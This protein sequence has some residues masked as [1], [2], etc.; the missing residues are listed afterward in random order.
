MRQF[1]VVNTIVDI[2]FSGKTTG[3]YVESQTETTLDCKPKIYI[4]H[5]VT[6]RDKL[7]NQTDTA[8]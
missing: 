8:R 1:D 6:L 7:K 5:G 3:N 2:V 4:V